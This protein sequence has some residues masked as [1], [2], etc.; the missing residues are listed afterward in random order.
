MGSLSL[1]V[2]PHRACSWLR[3]CARDGRDVCCDDGVEG[4]FQVH[5]I[6]AKTP[7]ASHLACP[8]LHNTR[9]W[10]ISYYA[11]YWTIGEE[12]M[13]GCMVQGGLSYRG[14]SPLS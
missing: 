13:K 11:D 12:R 3:I 9:T 2:R 4:N 1:F 10:E 8:G 5:F 7:D 6:C 14:R